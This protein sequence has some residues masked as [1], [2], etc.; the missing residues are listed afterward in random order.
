M[1]K[2]VLKMD[3]SSSIDN[4]I[5][6]VV[7]RETVLN[8]K[9]SL[10]RKIKIFIYNIAVILFSPRINYSCEKIF[11]INGK[12]QNRSSFFK[13]DVLKIYH[14]NVYNN[15]IDIFNKPTLYSICSRKKRIELFFKTIKTYFINKNQI[16]DFGSWLE[17]VVLE[18]FIRCSS[19]E[20]IISRGHYDEYATWLGI[21]S[22]Q[23]GFIYSIYQHGV[24]AADEYVK[25]RIE[26]NNFY[27]FDKYSIN[28]FRS[29]I[30]RNESCNYYLYDFPSSVHFERIDKLPN[31]YYIGIAEQDNYE[32]TSRIID[33]LLKT[34]NIRIILMLHPLS[35]NKYKYKKNS[36][37]KVTSKKIINIDLL[38]TENSTLA[39]DYYKKQKDFKIIFTSNESKNTFLEYPF[40]YC[41]SLNSIRQYIEK[42]LQI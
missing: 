37:I 26:C 28:I 42:E 2:V 7:N 27:A 30:I 40:L 33:M 38:I 13:K 41:E 34:S 15:F 6:G 18:N 10:F 25:N 1:I 12:S 16:C 19:V 21:L 8:R 32:W 31:N 24:V 17:Y 29:K 22:F 3:F 36:K 5:A 14:G 4:C 9:I 39:L 11:F 20:E 23:Y 35:K